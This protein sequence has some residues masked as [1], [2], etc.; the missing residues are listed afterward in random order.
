MFVG[1]KPQLSMAAFH[2]KRT[3]RGGAVGLVT[4]HKPRYHVDS[5][6]VF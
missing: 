3:L 5:G 4:G 6:S 1:M 2:P